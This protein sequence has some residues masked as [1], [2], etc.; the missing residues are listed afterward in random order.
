M[1]QVMPLKKFSGCLSEIFGAIRGAQ[2]AQIHSIKRKVL[3]TGKVSF[4]AERSNKNGHADK[5]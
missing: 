3:P 2:V 1:P 4:D 5:F